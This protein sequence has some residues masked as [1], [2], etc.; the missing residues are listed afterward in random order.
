MPKPSALTTN[1]LAWRVVDIAH[2]TPD[3]VN[4]VRVAEQV[5]QSLR[6]S[7]MT[8]AVTAMMPIFINAVLE[9]QLGGPVTLNERLA[10]ELR[11]PA[12]ARH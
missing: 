10:A 7:E 6:P 8:A 12:F 4:E 1:D 2:S 5:L 9:A 11:D 3:G